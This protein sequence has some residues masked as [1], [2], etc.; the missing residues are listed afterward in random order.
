MNFF[1]L[2]W[3]RHWFTLLLVMA[4]WQ[5]QAR[6]VYVDSAATLGANNGTS[7][8]D[9]YTSVA[10]ALTVSVADDTLWVARGTYY[11][12]PSGA[13]ASSFSLKRNVVV[14]GGFE[15]LTGAQE[16]APTQRDFQQ[17]V[18]ILSGD[19]DTSGTFTAADAY[20]VVDGLGE[21][22]TAVLDGFT[23]TGGHAVG[24]GTNNR[25]AALYVVAAGA[26]ILNC[27]LEN[28]FANNFGAAAFV[29]SSSV[30]LENCII[31][32]NATGPGGQGGAL[33][34][35]G[36]SFLRISNTVIADN[37]GGNLGGGALL[38]SADTRFI[39]CTFANNNA[40][41]GG[42]V[43]SLS[44]A[45]QF[46]NCIFW[47]NTPTQIAGTNPIVDHCIVQGGFSAGSDIIDA[48]PNFR[49]GDY[50]IFA[51]SPAVDAGDS[52]T[53]FVTD[54][55]GNPR[56]F[57]GD[58]DLIA[59]WDIGAF[60][61]QVAQTF[62]TANS[63]TGPNPACAR[64]DDF[65]Y[66]VTNNNFPTN[67]YAW[68]L[69]GGGG[70]FDGRTDSSTVLIDWGA[71][72]GSYTLEVQ[73]ISA[74]SGCAF[75]NT[76]NI[77]LDTVPVVTVAPTG[78]SP[79]CDGDSLQIS[80]AG[81]GNAFQ[82][83]RNGSLI[84]GATGTSFFASQSGIHNVILTDGNG[85]R[86]SAATAF[87]LVVNPLP[88]VT[89][90]PSGAPEI[91]IGNQLVITGTAG[92]SYQWFQNG[93]ALPGETNQTLTTG[94][95]GRYNLLLTDANT[96]T[97]SAATGV[98]L[99]V[100]PL[101][102]VTVNPAGADTLCAGDSLALTATAAGDTAYQWYRSGNLLPGANTNPF[103]GDMTGIYNVIL[104]DSN[105]CQDSA[106]VG[107]EILIGDFEN[108]VSVCG[109]TTLYL[110]GSGSAT[111]TP[112]MLNDGTTDNCGVDS[113]ALSQSIFL[114]ADT[115][116]S[117]VTL[118]AFD[119]FLNS[120]ACT[121]NV[122]VIDSTTPSAVCV[123]STGYLGASGQLTVGSALV[124]G[125]SAD[126]CGIGSALVTPNNFVCSDT[127]VQV[128]TLTVRDVSGSAAACTAN[129]TIA[130]S[131]RPN[132][133]CQDVNV[134]L[135]NAGNASI[136]LA[137]VENGSSDNCGIS[138]S[139]LSQTSFTCADVP[140]V[141]ITMTVV[142]VSG[143]A[144]TCQSFIRVE[145]TV[146][147]VV[148]CRDTIIYID[149]TGQALLTPADVDG[150]SSDNCGIDLSSLSQTLFTCIDTG[151]N[152]V[153]LS[154][155]DADTNISSCISVVTVR[156]T[157]PPM[158]VCSDTTF[159]LDSMG[160]AVVDPA[161][162]G[163]N[164]VDNC[165]FFDSA[166]VNVGPFTCAD[167]G[168]Q[169]VTLVVRDI[170]QRTDSCTGT[171]T[172]A[173][174]TAPFVVCRDTALILDAGGNASLT[175]ADLDGGTVDN[176]TLDTVFISQSAFTCADVGANNVLLTAIDV[177]GNQ[178][179][180]ISVVTIRDTVPPAAV[181][182]DTTLFLDA[183]GNAGIVAADLDGGSSDNCLIDTL[184]A[185]QLAFACA[186]TGVN[187]IQ[188]SVIDADSNVTN[189]TSLVT[190]RD[191]I[192]PTAVCGDT[193]LF[194]DAAGT[195]AL[196]PAAVDRGSFDNCPIDTF[197]LSTLSY[198]CSDTGVNA[199]A[200]T[201][202]DPS[203]NATACMVN[204]TV[205]D[206]TFPTAICA[207][208]TLYLDNNGNLN[209]STAD[210]A[211]TAFD[212]CGF[213]A[214]MVST[215]TFTCAD[216]GLQVIT[217]TFIDP[218]GNTSSCTSN[219]TVRDS[220][221]PM[222]ACRDTTLFLDGGGTATLLVSMV[223]T[224]STD[225]CG[226]ATRTLSQSNF[227]CADVGIPGVTLTVTDTQGNSDSCTVMV[228]V[229]DTISPVISCQVDTLYLDSN[230]LAVVIP[231]ALDAGS[232]DVC[233]IDTAFT[234]VQV[235]NCGNI[236][237]NLVQLTVQD[238]SGN[239][240]SCAASVLVLDT[241]APFAICDSLQLQL[242]STGF[243]VLTPALLGPNAFDNCAL[244][245]ST[246]VP[247]TFTCADFGMQTA[248]LFL[249]DQY[250][251]RDSCV[252]L[253]EV[254]D[255]TGISNVSISL[256]NDTL[257]CNGDTLFL[258]AGLGQASYLWSTGA[259]TP[260]ISTDSAGTYWVDVVSPAG[261]LGTD[262]IVI[263]TRNIP[264]P[265]LRTESG[266][267][268][269]CQNDSLRLEVDP[270]YATYLWSN[271]DTTP[272]TQVFTG[273][274]YTVQVIDTGGCRLVRGIDID[275][276][277]F[278][279]PNPAISPPDPAT[280]CEGELL[281]LDAGPGYFIYLWNTSQT[282]QVITAFQPGT[283]SVEVWN[284]FGCHTV[285]P[286]V[287]VTELPAPPVNVVQSG[288]TL[289]VMVTGSVQ[290]EFNGTPIP[291]ANQP[292]YV[293]TQNGV[294]TAQ[295][296]YANGCMRT[297]DPLTL[298]VAAEPSSGV[299]RGL[300]LYPNPTRDKVFL[301]PIDPIRERLQL[302]LT[303][304]FGRELLVQ[305]LRQ[306]VRERELDLSHLAQGV[307][308]LEVSAADGRVVYKVIRE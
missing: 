181:C 293:I 21:D 192:A 287:T 279:A 46:R 38:G 234:D 142:D 98:Q 7:W 304:V 24:P 19:L 267:L 32:N 82:W 79:V 104:T 134:I 307:Y 175:T 100:H 101:P 205:V 35:A 53:A 140:G 284:G 75:T 126:N 33:Y 156:D 298:L 305:D 27:R 172:I 207:D 217:A 128:V 150:G 280:Y 253:V 158:A 42:G 184:V 5:V 254:V 231:A 26:R 83:Y 112:A 241:L 173:D 170:N 146:A 246:V 103:F 242:G 157:V 248:T 16:T 285:A 4:G 76:L 57:D 66:T 259:T 149:S 308:L 239:A 232:S 191:T 122:T 18:C 13:N 219:L 201:V 139:F 132:A 144:G 70:T 73:E 303:D 44:A 23:I 251:N 102:V 116:T 92:V 50:R 258:D 105:G 193:T 197:M 11:P 41:T 209:I 291:G 106:A 168:S 97:D 36:T 143:N 160:V 283:Y 39:Q 199:I 109:D 78:T 290:W 260:V 153:T 272:T 162:F 154:V 59:R 141:N 180:C 96:C 107:H 165:T 215:A 286:P 63:I 28:N 8:T 91:C 130:D 118:T 161:I 169:S 147:P 213:A 127:G 121:G 12:G 152:N 227:A 171:V 71:T 164:S 1:P 185:A 295:V 81:S 210:I 265:N 208:T 274:N 111:L 68:N 90:S 25:G 177:F 15:G 204:I 119:Q 301:A 55:D 195:I 244:I 99:I 245:S 228:T 2:R 270:I 123:D 261:C 211:P 273:G 145:D 196:T 135:D 271:G 250:S 198:A 93:S 223:D 151:A 306:L 237:T 263:S 88:T 247:D 229:R 233:G 131:T 43:F 266:E 194:L 187:N 212:N 89:F 262:T 155:Q 136:A 3:H 220:T 257:V 125:G 47:G 183:S 17:N 288:D 69:P 94:T 275:F 40:G 268:V 95:A 64:G 60:E 249:E 252:G 20:H 281:D 86:D 238:P 206:S 230:G 278:P 224:G 264:E 294:Y 166:F 48:D 296:T 84:P 58:G 114:C 45:I 282:T 77:S 255:T 56:P 85:C 80:A 67:F 236:G 277:P 235:L 302:R 74:A 37:F 9:A 110:D 133:V 51:C 87:E 240:D 138:T 148:S 214:T 6:V 299:L 222:L 276:V 120:D 174:S 225:A 218:S 297:S 216:T 292:I 188:L 14:L 108:P 167:T 72:T 22:T 243:A 117:V 226:I 179:S 65:A 189:C 176:C 62:P 129:L 29:S 186:D 190:V 203:G 52:L 137:D 49:D 34:F 159:Y 200:L 163:I 31:K 115:G 269:I 10:N 221:P 113:F 54:R 61:N 124:D 289:S 182:R 178:R 30:Y 202:E 300:Q 256:G